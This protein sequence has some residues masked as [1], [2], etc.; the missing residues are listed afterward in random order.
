MTLESNHAPDALRKLHVCIPIGKAQASGA[1]TIPPGAAGL[2]LFESAPG[3]DDLLQKSFAQIFSRYKLATFLPGGPK[4]AESFDVLA[5]W[6]QRNAE[7]MG[8]HRGYFSCG[9]DSRAGVTNHLNQPDVRTAVIC[10]GQMDYAAGILANTAIPVLLIAAGRDPEG[11]R[12]SELAL[13]RL[14]KAS[15]LH[16]ISGASRGFREPGVAEEA[17]QLAALWFLHHLE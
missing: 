8:L 11:L 13:E 6:A 1:L 7:I 15:K 4:N 2:I 17:A 3:Q 9:S 16:V 14:N 5:D 10:G 12:S